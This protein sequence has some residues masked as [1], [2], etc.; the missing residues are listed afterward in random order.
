MCS[1]GERYVNIP[2]SDPKIL[3]YLLEAFLAFLFTDRFIDMTQDSFRNIKCLLNVLAVLCDLG[4]VE[5]L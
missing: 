1:Y 5:Y 3:R 2:L 4:V